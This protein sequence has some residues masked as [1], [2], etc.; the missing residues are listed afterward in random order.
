MSELLI[1]AAAI[2]ATYAAYRLGRRDREG[3]ISRA[4]AVGIRY[5][6]RLEGLGQTGG[7]HADRWDGRRRPVA[8]DVELQPAVRAL[9]T[10]ERSTPPGRYPG[11]GDDRS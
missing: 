1:L 10:R 8:Y 2:A 9:D 7:T 5:G 11:G 4:F 6:R 3:A